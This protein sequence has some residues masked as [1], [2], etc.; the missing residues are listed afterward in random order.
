MVTLIFYIIYDIFHIVQICASTNYTQKQI[1]ELLYS[2]I[3][4][5]FLQ[6]EALRGQQLFGN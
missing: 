4:K 1:T 5:I 2:V 6:M 3:F